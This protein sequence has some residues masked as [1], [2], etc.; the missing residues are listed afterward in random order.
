ML[1][2]QDRR[3][4]PV[5]QGSRRL[6]L[7]VGNNA[8]PGSPLRNA[9]NDA[10]AVRAALAGVG[11]EVDLQ[12]DVGM[13]QLDRAAGDFAARVR[14]GDVALFY[15]SG[16]GMQLEGENYLIPVDFAA[17]TAV[18]ARYQSYAA[19][20]IQGNLEAAG[21]ALQIIILDACRDNPFRSLRSG[22][23]GLT[24]MQA[25]KGAYIAFATA[26]GKTAD[27]NRAGGNGLFTGALVEAL[28]EPG[29]TLDQ[30]FSHARA[31]V[32]AVRP[33]QVPWSA[34]SVVGEFYFRP[35]AAPAGGAR[36]P[37]S[38]PDWDAWETIRASGDPLLFDEFLKEYPASAYAGAA[39][40]KL[41]SL[42]SAPAP[43]PSPAPG[44]IPSGAAAGATKVN[45]KDGLTYVWIKPGTF[46]MGCS[47]GDTEC[48]DQEKPAHEVTITKGFWMGQTDV[49]QE[50]YQR[51][52]GNNPSNFKGA[53]LPVETINWNEAQSY[54]Q[55]IGMRLPTEAEWEYAARA[56]STGARYGD[57]DRV[58]WYSA[59]S[60]GKTHEVAQKEP[61]A[62][63]LYDMLGNVWQWVSD[64]YADKYP[65]GSQ[66]DPAGAANG[67]FRV[68]RGGSWNFDPR[69]VRAS[70]RS[71][72][73][74][75]G[76]H[77]NV[78]VRCAGN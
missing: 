53:R 4:A 47:P 60:G 78:G 2:A 55:A 6:A 58:A 41:A 5:A 20:R 33:E 75:E 46:K 25:G 40:L 3:V 32:T 17:R 52:T 49:T 29:L 26:P 63:G 66:P 57:L 65:G 56:G 13:A 38:A 64:W 16:H 9:V 37:A 68:L 36:A 42:R 11:F 15:Y 72:G 61:N 43:A 51:V 22:A 73:G 67:Q 50:A 21:A 69:R 59:N 70:Y 44:K 39:R 7:V 54:C 10:R 35:P 1:A 62:F 23:G 18:D 14:P 74:P 30:V 71:G 77:V 19:S 8:Y 24:A 27:D 34:T 31:K 76:R 48:S 12:T 28:G 45:P